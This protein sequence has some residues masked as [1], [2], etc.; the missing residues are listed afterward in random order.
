MVGEW[1]TRRR[2][3]D[4]ANLE[5]LKRTPSARTV[6]RLMTGARDDLSRAQTVTVAAIEAAAPALVEA[7]D[8]VDPS[9][10]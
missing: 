7:R 8:I 10:R 1:V 6:A 4:E 5:R 2:R 3:A 9:T